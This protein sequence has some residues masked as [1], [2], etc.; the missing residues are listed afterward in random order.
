LSKTLKIAVDCRDVNIATTGTKTYLTELI[1]A[2]KTLQQTD[3][4]QNFDNNFDQ[5]F[6]LVLIEPLLGV[7]PGNSALSKLIRHFQFFWWKQITLPVLAF[8][9]GANIL[10]CTD[11]VAPIITPGFK[12][13]VVF[14]DAFFW[15]YPQ[16][17]SAGWLRIFKWFALR[18]AKKSISVIAPTEYA[19]KQ[20][21]LYT[22]IPAAKMSV[23]YEA[24]KTFAPS[25]SQPQSN[26]QAQP[27]TSPPIS[28]PYFLHVGTLAKHKNL[29]TLIEAFALLVQKSSIDPSIKLV[30][31]GGAPS[32]VYSNDEPNIIAAIQKHNLQN[33]VVL[34][35][36]VSSNAVANWYS[37][38]IG[39][40]FPSR[41]EGFGLPMLEAMCY[42]L[43]II[44]AN[45]TC[46]PEIGQGAALY[47]DPNNAPRIAVLLEAIVNNDPSVIASVNAQSI[48]LQQFSWKK[49]AKQFIQIAAKALNNAP[50]HA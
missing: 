39:Y 1:A 21:A 38:A 29:V 7:M 15:E 24:P 46:L 36:Y 2:L 14:H 5:N 27:H 20:I 18:S 12:T 47:F 31:V 3:A 22:G 25:Q 23:V 34:T 10:I 13:M 17:Y 32:S 40:V 48:V 49:T 45:N 43:P 42:H 41:N 44:A 33:R 35:G 8:F 30:L 11:Y 4:D 50:K 6:E 19:K 9:K 26:A 37:G 28:A 16:H